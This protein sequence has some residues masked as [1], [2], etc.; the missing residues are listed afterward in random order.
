MTRLS[1]ALIRRPR[2]LA[3]ACGLLAA[4]TALPTRAQTCAPPPA[5][6]V[7]WWPLNETSGTAVA[8]A[9]GQNPG[10]ASVSIGGSG[11]TSKPGLVGSGLNFFFGARVN[12]NTSVDFDG[13]FTIDAWVNGTTSPIV[14][15]YRSGNKTGFSLVFDVNTLRFDMH[16]G[17]TPVLINGPPIALNTWTFVAVVVDRTNKQVTLYTATPGG[18]LATS[19]APIPN[20]V[21]LRSNLPLLIGGCPGNP[22][23]C[24]TT[25][26]EVEIFNRALTQA[27]LQAIVNAGKAGKCKPSASGPAKGMTWRWGGV[28]ATSGAV[29]VGCGPSEPRPCNASVGDQLC[30]DSLPLLCFK[31]N[32]VLPKPK[33]VVETPYYYLWSGGIVAT[34]PPVAPAASPISSSLTNANKRCEEEFG[35]DWRVAEFHDGAQGRGGWNFHAYGNMGDPKSR[36]WVHINDQPKGTC[37]TKK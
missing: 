21:N 32:P 11:I 35:K 24:R 16:T 33:S 14:S 27:E 19:G 25:I 7:G 1:A 17:S 12:A 13:S 15:S 22:N 34:T 20:N 10:T 4:L 28:D 18:G 37:F 5:G 29:T 8:D 30:T 3:V 23:G 36:F 9:L 2:T 26:D 6:L 31:P